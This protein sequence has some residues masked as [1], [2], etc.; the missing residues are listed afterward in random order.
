[1]WPRTAPATLFGA[2]VTGWA[3]VRAA[4]EWPGRG[5]PLHVLPQRDLR[6]RGQR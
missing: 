4:F 1:M 5:S 2:A 3:G 6:G